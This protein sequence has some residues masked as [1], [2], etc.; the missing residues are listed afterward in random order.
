MRFKVTKGVVIYYKPQNKT[1]ICVHPEVDWK[2]KEK[3]LLF[4]KP[5]AEPA[6]EE[7]VAGGITCHRGDRGRLDG[8]G[9]I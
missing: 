5:L 7:A 9:R 8:E 2:R 3:N 1:V 4:Q 6:R